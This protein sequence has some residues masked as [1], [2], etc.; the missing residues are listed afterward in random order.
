MNDWLGSGRG[1]ER[2]LLSVRRNA[3]GGL[4]D[5]AMGECV[6]DLDEHLWKA[7]TER[8]LSCGAARCGRD[9][10]V[11]ESFFESSIGG[12]AFACDDEQ[13]KLVSKAGSFCERGEDDVEAQ[14]PL[15]GC[16]QHDSESCVLYFTAYVGV[17]NGTKGPSPFAFEIALRARGESKHMGKLDQWRHGA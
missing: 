14:E 15:G 4:L 3:H 13:S 7:R 6:E 11:A 2:L 10:C 17:E 12:A 5:G 8:E 16:G 9:A 1:R